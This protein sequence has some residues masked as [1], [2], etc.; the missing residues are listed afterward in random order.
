M[1]KQALY[2]LLRAVPRGKVVTYGTLA[3]MLGNRAWARAVGNAL[4]SNQ[5]GEKYPCYRVVNCKGELSRA[6]AFGGLEEQKR[7]LRKDGI[8]V[9]NGKVDLKRYGCIIR[10]IQANVSGYEGRN[11][12]TQMLC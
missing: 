3:E 6:Y 5:D 4:H 12:R 8:A 9:E 2:E 1:D 7:R 11:I 10:E